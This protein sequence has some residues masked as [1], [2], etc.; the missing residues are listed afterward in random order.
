M[1]THSVVIGHG[2]SGSR[3]GGRR[4][5][6]YM[7]RTDGTRALTGVGLLLSAPTERDQAVDIL[8]R[9]LAVV[10]LAV[11]AGCCSVWVGETA[12][13]PP[14]RVAYEAYSLVGT[15]AA[16]TGDPSRRVRGR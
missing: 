1:I 15:L 10:D 11:D 6:R 16:R 5:C 7:V 12:A 8:S 9:A 4:Y 2:A 3:P 13:D 14:A